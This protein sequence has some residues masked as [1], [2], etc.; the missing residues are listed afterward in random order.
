MKIDSNFIEQWGP[1]YD[2]IESDEV[3]YLNLIECVQEEVKTLLSIN[4][5]TFQRIINWKSPRVKG[6][7]EWDDYAAYGKTFRQI[8]DPKCKG[9]ISY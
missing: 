8:L 7:I 6:K 1:K 4:L 9:K 2:D 3:E 5:E